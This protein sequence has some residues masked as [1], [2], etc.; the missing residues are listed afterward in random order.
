MCLIAMYV[1]LCV[2]V[3]KLT[4]AIDTSPP[5]IEIIHIQISYLTD[6]TCCLY[7]FNIIWRIF[8]HLTAFTP[9]PTE[10]TFYL[11]DFTLFVWIYTS[12]VLFYWMYA[13]LTEFISFWLYLLLMCVI[14][15][16][17]VWMCPSY[18]FLLI[19]P[20][21]YT[22]CAWNY[23]SSDC[24]YLFIFIYPNFTP[25]LYAFYSHLS[26]CALFWLFTHFVSHLICVVLALNKHKKGCW[27][28]Q[29]NFPK[30]I[31]SHLIF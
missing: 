16:S 26:E 31:M 21:F 3:L 13:H 23:L 1:C 14:L 29:Y 18:S 27:N 24:I 12:S 7:E 22:S 2:C 17:P 28:I 6:F 9:Y 15:Q 30:L 10:C 4:A 5:H 8:P 25:R 11:T 20:C 19:L